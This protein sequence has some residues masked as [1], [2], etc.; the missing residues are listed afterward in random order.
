MM[1]V[2]SAAAHSD[3]APER[4]K[5]MILITRTV[6]KDDIEDLLVEIEE[7][8]LKFSD[9]ALSFGEKLKLSHAR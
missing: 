8:A 7:C 1:P 5:A 6:V 2:L 9:V 4:T 3:S